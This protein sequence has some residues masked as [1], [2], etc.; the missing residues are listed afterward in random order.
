MTTTRKTA[1]ATKAKAPTKA[2]KA[3]TTK[4]KA[5]AY[6]AKTAKAADTNAKRGAKRFYACPTL[7]EAVAK[8]DELPTLRSAKIGTGKGRAE[9]EARRAHCE[10]IGAP[11][12]SVA[13]II[14]A[15]K[16]GEI[17]HDRPE[18]TVRARLISLAKA[19]G[20]ADCP[21]YAVRAEAW[22]PD[23][24]PMVFIVRK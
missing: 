21:W 19:V 20:K 4:A 2:R 12:V 18:N 14:H 17:T 9:A 8:A 11:M 13:Q 24:I 22:T 6:L 7:A 15:N 16:A 5:T 23:E 10:K 1:K 3:T